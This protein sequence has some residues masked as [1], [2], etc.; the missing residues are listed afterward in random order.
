G[1]RADPGSRAASDGGAGQLA[2]P[3]HQRDAAIL[4]ESRNAGVMGGSQPKASLAMRKRIARSISRLPSY[5]STSHTEPMIPANSLKK[6]YADVTR[7][8]KKESRRIKG[9]V[10]SVWVAEE[11]TRR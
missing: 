3:S 9:N 1:A 11:A 7:L 8:L 5:Y 4:T 2:P 10:R 6:F